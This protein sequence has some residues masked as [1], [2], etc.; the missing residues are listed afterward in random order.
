M[1]TEFQKFLANAMQATLPDE[2]N[3]SILTGVFRD[4]IA[5]LDMTPFINEVEYGFHTVTIP[6]GGGGPIFTC[7][8]QSLKAT[9]RYHMF[10]VGGPT[11][12]SNNWVT[13][14]E[15]PGMP[16][17]FV[18]GR[19]KPASITNPVIPVGKTSAGDFIRAGPNSQGEFGNEYIGFAQ[20]FNVYPTGVLRLYPQGNQ[21]VGNT[22]SLIY[23]R[24]LL[25]A[26]SSVNRIADSF[27]ASF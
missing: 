26:P 6:S 2:R 3:P 24:E 21:S 13:A 27:A 19:R 14:I 18:I 15:Y 20:P 12:N 9:S 1:P 25:V 17:V 7:L 16:S 22:F 23:L 10:G 8:D 5:T 11:F 4:A